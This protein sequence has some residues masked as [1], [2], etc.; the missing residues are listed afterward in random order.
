MGPIAVKLRRADE[1]ARSLRIETAIVEIFELLRRFR[2]HDS[3][4]QQRQEWP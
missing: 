2:A 4:A 1:R 3:L